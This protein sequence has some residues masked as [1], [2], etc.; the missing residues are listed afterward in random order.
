M[1]TTLPPANLKHTHANTNTPMKTVFKTDEIPHIWQHARAAHGRCPASMSFNGPT[2]YSY[3]TVMGVIHQRVTFLN[4]CRYSKTTSKH[5]L[6]IRRAVS[7]SP[8][9]FYQRKNGGVQVTDALRSPARALE[10]FINGAM[11]QAWIAGQIQAT[12]PRRK[13][14]IADYQA[15]SVQCY[16]SA[17]RIAGLFSLPCTLPESYDV[18]ALRSAMAERKKAEELAKKKAEKA[19]IK[20]AKEDLQRWL[21]GDDDV[22]RCALNAL[23]HAY[24][25][26]E[27]GATAPF[28]YSSLGVTIPLDEARLAIAFISRH[29]AK[30]WHRNGETYTI[31]GYHLEAINDQGIV[32]GCHRVTW[33]EFDRFAATMPTMPTMP[34]D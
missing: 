12:H 10:Y 22:S 16:D 24:F 15:A 13:K 9:L 29:R 19:R 25:R 8:V 5:Q 20:K 1:K 21:A 23:P 34:S 18:G 3:S 28:V 30:G 27:P 17:R 6:S 31:G 14:D 2:I 32:A 7:T 11:E 4:R 33:A 26:I